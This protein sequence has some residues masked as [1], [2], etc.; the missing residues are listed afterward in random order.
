VA[1]PRPRPPRGPRRGRGAGVAGIERQRR[2]REFIAGG[3]VR[4]ARFEARRETVR[5]GDAWDWSRN[6]FV[7]TIELDALRALMVLFN[8]YD[9][10][11]A[12]N[13]VIDVR[14]AARHE[15][16]YV[17]AD[18]G[19]SFGQVGGL[20]GTRSKG[21]LDGYRSSPFIERVADGRV[22]FAYRTRPQGWARSLFVLNPFYTS[23]ELKKERDLAQ[24][25]VTAARWLGNRLAT[26]PPATLRDAFD[27]AGYSPEAAAGFAE[28]LV[29]RINQLS[30]L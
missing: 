30:R 20:G 11:T 16:L 5:R 2:G 7:G 24:V 27:D 28:V 25:P 10:R 18:L 4:H 15:T 19:A 9:A 17:V 1:L 29:A 14:D 21:D 3:A 22:Y 8:N 23:G 12:N 13:R 6:P 26:L